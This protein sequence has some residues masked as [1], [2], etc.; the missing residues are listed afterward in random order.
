MKIS[1]Q[2]DFSFLDT[3]SWIWSLGKT[4][5]LDL[6]QEHTSAC[7]TVSQQVL[8][9]FL[10]AQSTQYIFGHHFPRKPGWA[11]LQP[12]WLRIQV[13]L[14][15]HLSAL[16][17]INHAITMKV[18]QNWTRQNERCLSKLGCTNSPANLTPPSLTF[19]GSPRQTRLN[20]ACGRPQTRLRKTLSLLMYA[21]KLNRYEINY[22]VRGDPL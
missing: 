18:C 21:G 6:L 11:K 7:V 13:L 5:R 10:W 22:F 3:I 1:Y 20:A 16:P 19:T 2:S 15:V 17:I 14:Q 4:F 8:Q 12:L 9:L